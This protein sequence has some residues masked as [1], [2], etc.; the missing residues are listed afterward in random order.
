MKTEANDTA[1][2]KQR[3]A[4]S[5]YNVSVKISRIWPF[6]RDYRII[7]NNHIATSCHYFHKTVCNIMAASIALTQTVRSVEIRAWMQYREYVCK[8]TASYFVTYQT[9]CI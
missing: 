7:Q 3:V 1:R 5:W 2:A 4:A 6:I 9:D 8:T